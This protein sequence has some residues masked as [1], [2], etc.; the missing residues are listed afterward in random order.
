[1]EGKDYAIK[2][3]GGETKNDPAGPLKKGEND[4]HRLKPRHEKTKKRIDY[5]PNQSK[6][7]RRGGTG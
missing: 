7:P 3:R 6:R 4:P 1:M 2:R 5:N